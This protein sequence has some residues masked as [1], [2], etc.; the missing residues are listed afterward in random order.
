LFCRCYAQLHDFIRAAL[1]FGVLEPRADDDRPDPFTVRAALSRFLALTVTQLGHSLEDAAQTMDTSVPADARAQL[2][3]Y[4]KLFNAR[5]WDGVRA[6]LGEDCRL[7]LVAKSQRRGK[8]VGL[9]FGNYARLEVTRLDGRDVLAAYVD[10]ATT[11]NYYIVLDS[12]TGAC[13]RS[14]TSGTCR[15]SQERRLA[16]NRSRFL[17]STSSAPGKLVSSFQF[18][19]FSGVGKSTKLENFPI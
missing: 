13:S 3:A 14:A 1:R 16:H 8:A 9:Y 5:D 12:R 11:P 6:M 18:R 19:R 15:T 4:A 7:D 2:T 17:R 10:G